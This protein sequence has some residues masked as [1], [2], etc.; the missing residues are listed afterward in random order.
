MDTGLKTSCHATRARVRRGAR[1][2]GS[3]PELPRF[4]GDM[5]VEE[6]GC[7][8]VASESPASPCQVG[9]V[10]PRREA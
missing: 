10:H 7:F 3:G 2:N 4:I 6:L 1:G 8:P 5:N 9:W